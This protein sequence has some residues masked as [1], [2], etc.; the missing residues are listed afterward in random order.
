[1]RPLPWMYDSTLG[2]NR[3]VPPR[4]PVRDQL[5]ITREVY[6]T[7][8]QMTNPDPS[9]MA[10]LREVSEQY[11]LALDLCVTDEPDTMGGHDAWVKAEWAMAFWVGST[12]GG[13]AI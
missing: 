3:P 6:R 11:R 13:A 9:R 10:R 1:L 12:S 2:A 5:G 8:R 4:S 7:E